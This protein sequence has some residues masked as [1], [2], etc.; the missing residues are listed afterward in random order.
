MASTD[1]GAEKPPGGKRKPEDTLNLLSDAQDEEK[2][3]GSELE[4]F[5]EPPVIKE[6]M[7]STDEGPEE[8]PGGQQKSQDTLD[9]LSDAG[10]QRRP[11]ESELPPFLTIGTEERSEKKNAYDYQR[12]DLDSGTVYICEKKNEWCR[13]NEVLV[14]KHEDGAWIAYVADI[15]DMKNIQ[16]RQGVWCCR[17]DDITK[18]GF[19]KAIE[20]IWEGSLWC[21]TRQSLMHQP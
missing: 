12:R 20:A 11:G 13:G 5:S 1:G 2:T 18:K 7:A 17:E 9:L 6:P 15:I 21:E 3:G 4:G 14:L 19:G 16:C 10:G 8:P